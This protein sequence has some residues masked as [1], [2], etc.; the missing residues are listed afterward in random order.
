[1]AKL[2]LDRLKKKYGAKG[3]SGANYRQLMALI[4]GSNHENVDLAVARRSDEYYRGRFRALQKTTAINLKVPPLEE[5]MPR[6]PIYLRKGAEHG[7][8]ITDALRDRLSADLR[9]AVK[10]FGLSGVGAMQY[11]RGET[12]GR[13]HPEL[14]AQFEAAIT[15]TFDNYTKS[16][17][18]E[19]PANISTI[20]ETEVRSAISD[21]KHTYAQ[22][23]VSRNPGRLKAVKRWVHHANLSSEARTGHVEMNGKEMRLDMPF[24]VPLYRMERGKKVLVQTDAMLHPHDPGSPPEQVI[25]CH[26]ECDYLMEVIPAHKP[27]ASVG[28]GA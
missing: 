27:L 11:K 19:I 15:R 10:Q 13:M 24:H 28:R 17:G 22:E 2:Y 7:V 25:N 18:G 21:I 9:D 23:L 4:I 12:R 14:V 26:C 6:K 20:A 5:I 8:M 1:M 3:W 16:K